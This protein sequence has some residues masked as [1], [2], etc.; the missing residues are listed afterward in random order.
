M[1]FILIIGNLFRHI[2]S[3]FKRGKVVTNLVSNIYL[4]TEEAMIQVVYPE[5]IKIDEVKAEWLERHL[6]QA[7]S[8]VFGELLELKKP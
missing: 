5:E 1:S 2:F 3:F 8:K 6:S 4:S 7:V